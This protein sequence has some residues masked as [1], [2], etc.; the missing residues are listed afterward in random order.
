MSFDSFDRIA[1]RPILL[2]PDPSIDPHRHK[3]IEVFA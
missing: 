1:R 2:G 3:T